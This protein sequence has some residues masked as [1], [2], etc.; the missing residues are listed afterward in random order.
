MIR[1]HQENN[2]KENFVK[3]YSFSKIFIERH[4]F[5]CG[6]MH[7]HH[8][9]ADIFF[10]CCMY[11]CMDSTDFN[12]FH[13]EMKRKV[14]E[15]LGLIFIDSCTHAKRLTH[16][17]FVCDKVWKHFF[18]WISMSVCRCEAY[19]MLSSYI[20]CSVWKIPLHVTMLFFSKKEIRSSETNINNFHCWTSF[21]I[22]K[23]DNWTIESLFP[24][25]W[26]IQSIERENY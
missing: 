14:Q 3:I 5:T 1:Y 18:D 2:F 8:H 24:T 21:C 12:L 10:Q 20:G 4:L 23:Q 6:Y 19:L 26:R 22:I 15:W 25:V 17:H 16:A 7:H 11:E 13:F 9:H